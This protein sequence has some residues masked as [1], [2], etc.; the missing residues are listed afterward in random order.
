M[1]NGVPAA[2]SHQLCTDAHCQCTHAWVRVPPPTPPPSLSLG[3]EKFLDPKVSV[4]QN[5]KT[6]LH[7]GDEKGKSESSDKDKSSGKSDGDSTAVSTTT[8]SKSFFKRDLIRRDNLARGYAKLLRDGTDEQKALIDTIQKLENLM[9]G[10]DAWSPNE[11]KYR[12]TLTTQTSF[13]VDTGYAAGQSRG[14]VDPILS[15]IN[16]YTGVGTVPI[17]VRIGAQ[18]RLHKMRISW[19]WYDATVYTSNDP[20]KNRDY[21]VRTLIVRQKLATANPVVVDITSAGQM[22][23]EPG[24]FLWDPFDVNPRT[25]TT[26]LEDTALAAG[27]SPNAISKL[28]NDI[29]Y[30]RVERNNSGN[31]QTVPAA[32]TNPFTTWVSGMDRVKDW[33]H[34]E[35]HFGHGG[36]R[37]S[38]ADDT[39]P[40]VD[41]I[42]NAIYIGW[43]TDKPA[44]VASA[45]GTSGVLRRIISRT[46]LYFTDA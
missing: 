4:S 36:L 11:M 12:F 18:I 8:Q 25:G 28:N 27:Y 2:S 40:A 1:S 15:T 34:F 46:E 33:T 21:P 35:H 24:A 5:S 23:L 13:D 16:P 7:C 19:K 32:G 45:T 42:E 39:T 17:D 30:D 20:M 29:M 31:G 26:M 22:P 37:V 9:V 43:C 14:L 41:P 3:N 10:L 44:Y 6:G 38:Y